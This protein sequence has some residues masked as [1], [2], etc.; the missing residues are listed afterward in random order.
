MSAEVWYLDAS[1]LVKTVIEEP[2]SAE[3]L[4]CL[5]DKETLAACDPSASRQ[6]GLAVSPIRPPSRALAQRSER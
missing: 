2:Q 1:A 5:R 6:S 3:L 4:D